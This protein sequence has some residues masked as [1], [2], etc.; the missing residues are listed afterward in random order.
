MSLKLKITNSNRKYLSI[1]VL[2]ISIMFDQSFSYL[3]FRTI[4]SIELRKG[5][6]DLN[7][8]P[9]KYKDA[10]ADIKW[11][12]EE[13]AKLK[14]KKRGLWT[15]AEA[16]DYKDDMDLLKVVR[17]EKEE[18]LT[19]HLQQI[20]DK[21]NAHGFNFTMTKSLF[22]NKEVFSVDSTDWAQFFVMKCLI[23]NVAKSFNV[24]MVNR[25]TVM[26]NLKLLMNNHMPVFII[27]TDVSS[28]FES[29]PQKRMMELIERNSV[30]SMKSKDMVKRTMKQYES[31]KNKTLVAEGVGVPRGI[32]ISSVLSEIYMLDIDKELKG[33]REVIFYSRYVDDIFIILSDLGVHRTKEEYYSQLQKRFADGYGLTLQPVG[34]QKCKLLDLS[35][36]GGG[37]KTEV[38]T[39]LGYKMYIQPSN[40]K[41]NT[42]FGLSDERKQR[43]KSRVD[44]VV[45]RFNNVVKVNI[46][47]A[48]RDLKDGLNLIT[49]N[50]R[51]TK[52]KSGVKVGFFYNNDL[53]DKDEDFQEMEDYLK[54]IVIT[55]PANLF[56]DANDNARFEAKV[57]AYVNGISLRD[58]WREKKTYDI[59][60]D[61]LKEIERWL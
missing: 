22:E 24:E 10:V 19:N 53:L 42:T 13:I 60:V 8:M 33:R 27:R 11:L 14:R 36:L 37:T 16:K 40:R 50:I 25:H 45:N 56:Q 41:R 29:I 59:G 39:Y 17:D 31:I 55:V 58:R 47:Q 15:E 34:S 6:I 7:R 12:N 38:L 54:H 35:Q 2:F 4:F 49:G 32:G 52:A 46:A 51:L 3:N 28:F 5:H 61:R 57:K 18:C 48:K 9:Q 44:H 30:L 1:E 26:M 21:V 20:A 43:F 23:R